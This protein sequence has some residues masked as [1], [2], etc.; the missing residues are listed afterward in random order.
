[1]HSQFSFWRQLIDIVLWLDFNHLFIRLPQ[2]A[3]RLT[4]RHKGMCMDSAVLQA[5]IVSFDDFLRRKLISSENESSNC[6]ERNSWIVR[7]DNRM[8]G[9]IF[10]KISLTA[11]A[12]LSRVKSAVVAN[13]YYEEICEQKFA[14]SLMNCKCFPIYRSW[15]QLNGTETA[16]PLEKEK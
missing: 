1:M 3:I 13:Q 6:L 8:R 14:D 16:S 9:I 15:L 7:A 10:E 4:L 11:G 2:V 5:S 12:L